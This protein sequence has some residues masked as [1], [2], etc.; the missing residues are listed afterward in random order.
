M[1]PLDLASTLEATAAREAA[2]IMERH[3]QL[4]AGTASRLRGDPAPAASPLFLKPPAQVATV[5]LGA[6]AVARGAGPAI[7]DLDFVHARGFGPSIASSSG[8][9]NASLD[10]DGARFGSASSS[11]A[12]QTRISRAA[13][14]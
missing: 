1:M 5:A 4:R 8:S 14:R 13:I 2:P 11:A 12:V 10:Q 6:Q 9:S 7:A 3:G